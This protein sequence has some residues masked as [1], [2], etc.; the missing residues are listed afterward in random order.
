M[1]K[2]KFQEIDMA[3]YK[4]LG[5]NEMILFCLYSV[6]GE[7]ERCTFYRLVK[8]CFS[9]FPKSFGFIEYPEWPDSRKFDRALRTL[10]A[11]KLI[12]GDPRHS[13]SITKNGKK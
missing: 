13:F 2:K 3:V 11:G 12:I 9:L 10:R 6:G 4:N 5:I 7:K 8:E 1:I